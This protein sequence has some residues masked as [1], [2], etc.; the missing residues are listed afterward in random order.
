[1]TKTPLPR[2]TKTCQHCSKSFETA[3]DARSAQ[4]RFCDRNCSNAATAKIRSDSLRNGEKGYKPILCP[5]GKTVY[6]AN[7]REY[8]YTKK[9]CDEICRRKYMINGNQRDK[10]KW[11]TYICLNCEES[12]ERRVNTRN[13]KK[14]CSNK[15]AQK[16]T[17]V[18][19]HY[20]VEGLEI[21]FDST[22][23]A[24]F[25]GIASIAKLPIERFDRQYAVEWKPGQFYAPD[26]WMPSVQWVTNRI[27]AAI[28]IKGHEEEDDQIKW[29]VFRATG[30]DLIIID[31]YR[32]EHLSAHNLTDTL[33]IACGKD[34]SL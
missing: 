11:T 21:V 1:M 20:G 29:A 30:V 10:S 22:W 18:K 26:F 5:C 17:K 28:E 24:A 25:W 15:C 34:N 19:K 7:D 27:G 32:M 16:H 6:G 31:Q 33:R 9:Y 12:F 13:A 14:Y 3:G 2:L 8:N 23:E 4:R